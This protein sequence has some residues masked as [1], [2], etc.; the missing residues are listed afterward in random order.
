MSFFNLALKNIRE[1]FSS[2]LIYLIS[3]IFAVTIFNIFC[4]IYYNPQFSQYRFGEGK[5]SVL[6][7]ASAVAV[8]LFASVFVFYANAFFVKTRKKEIAVYSLLGMKKKQVGRMLFYENMI[9]GLLAIACGIVI[10]TILSRFFAMILASLMATGTKVSFAVKW[11]AIVV[12]VCAFLI[13]FVVNSL[14]AY[15]IIYRYR[16]VELLSANKEREKIPR[17][18]IVG[19][20]LAILFIIS[21]YIIALSMDVNKGGLKLLLPSFIVLF[22]VVT[23]TL[24]LFVNFIPMILLK[25]KNKNDFYYKTDNFISMS[26]IVYRIKANSKILSVIAVLSAGTITLMSSTY[27]MYKGLEDTTSYYSPFSFM[28]KNIDEV[29]YNNI[30]KTIKSKNEVKVI[31]SNRFNLI[32]VQGQS[33]T[34]SIETENK[35]GMRFSGYVISQSNYKSIIKNTST[36]TGDFSNLR[37]NFNI[38]LKSDECFFIDGNTSKGY[39][40]NLTGEYIDLF[41]KNEIHKYKIAGVS[42]HKYLGLFDLYRK[43]T[44]VLDDITFNQYMQ[45]AE[46]KDIVGITGLV[47]DKPMESLNTVNEINSI[48]PENPQVKNAVGIKNISLIGFY[49]SAFSLYGAY[50]F[51]G[52]FLGILFLL[53]GG[54]ILYYKQIIEAQEE[55]G[56]YDIL[57][58]IGM[59]EKEIRH[60][61]SKQLAIIFSIP[62]LIGLLH[63]I[64]A[65]LTYNRTMDILGHETPTIL[66]AF[67]IVAIYIFIYCFYYVLSAASYTKIVLRNNAR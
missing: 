49:K 67:L 57:R 7:K 28:C 38:N 9:I 54:S 27:S 35:P 60:S 52:F 58:K 18:S 6:F 50:V 46:N 40:E 39:C 42:M 51:I 17:Y 19:G 10:G 63:S 30:I 1:K 8:I 47:F 53:A 37:T 55:V 23:G 21:G 12:T 36:K 13:L 3:T 34:Y 31:S 22:L 33:K 24:L 62:L 14:N 48:I 2:Y 29:Q 26:Q 41:F 45:M 56:R 4:S 59:N 20:A 25:L 43:P 32:Q 11:Q 66:N 64:I 15:V 65:I 61:I 44:L 5:M 16:L